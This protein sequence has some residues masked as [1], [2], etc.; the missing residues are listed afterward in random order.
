MSPQMSFPDPV[1]VALAAASLGPVVE[2]VEKL[3]EEVRAMPRGG[4]LEGL[5]ESH[6]AVLNRQCYEVCLERRQE[7][8]AAQDKASEG[9]EDFSPSGVPAVPGAVAAGTVEAA[10]DPN[11][12]R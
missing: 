1:G 7:A 3:V 2:T 4:D 11:A 9:S 6:L 5:I 10:G 8:A 12:A